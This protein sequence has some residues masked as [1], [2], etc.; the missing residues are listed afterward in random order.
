MLKPLSKTRLYEEIV[1]QL[2][3]RIIRREIAPGEKL[4]TE[5][6]LAETLQV[7]RST[8]REAL[9]KLETLDLVEIRHGD[10]VYVKDYLESG[11][12]E[13]VHELLFRNGRL[14]IPVFRNL[15]DL[16]R[17]LVPEMA[18]CAARNRSE[19]DVAA[20][21]AIVFHS[22]DKSVSVRDK[23]LH[24]VIARASGNVLFVLMLN[25]FTREMDQYYNLYFRDDRHAAESEA[26]HRNIYEAID[27]RDAN[28][29]KQVM[30]DALIVAE[31]NMLRLMG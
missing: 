25:A 24:H 26:F 16:R 28:R 7:N 27:D 22:G 23:R 8:V 15:L 9:K 21:G 12:L 10:G 1:E 31:D 11:S 5:R 18:R 29:A 13:L 19:V 14:E 6:S 17:L 20:L 30:L 3:G 2:K 4:P